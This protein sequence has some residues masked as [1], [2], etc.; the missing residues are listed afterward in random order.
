MWEAVVQEEVKRRTSSCRVSQVRPAGSDP[1]R[2]QPAPHPTLE[3]RTALRS[4]SGVLVALAV[5]TA[6]L[7]VLYLTSSFFMLEVYDRVVPS[8]SVPTLIA[9]ALLALALF[10][11][12]GFLDIIR[13]RVLIRVGSWLDRTLS[14][15]VYDLVA[16]LPL[17]ARTSGDGLQPLRDLD[18]LRTFLSGL[19]PTALFD[20]PWMPFYLALCYLFH[21]LIGLT[22]L[23]GSI[24]LVTLTILTDILTR[25]P[26]KQ[27]TREG[28]SRNALAEASR[29]NAEVLQAMGMRSR[30][31][32]LWV[33]AN[34]KYLE[35]QQRAFEISGTFGSLSKVLRIALQSTVL[36]VGGYLVIKQ[37]ASSG[38]IIA[39]AILTSRAL[40]PVELAIGH[41]KGLVTA[42]HGWQRL[43]QLTE[44][45]PEER[46]PTSLPAPRKSFTVEAVS[47]VPPGQ[48]LV[49][50]QDV[51]FALKAGQG[52]GIIGAS[53]SG[54]SSLVRA[55][56][57]AWIPARG[58]VRLDGA[59]LD[60]WATDS[61]GLHIGYLPQ[62]VEL[63]AG[64]VAQ[65]ISR[66][67]ADPSGEAIV[68]A[69]EAAGVH[70]LALRLPEGYD[71]PIGE[72][73]ASLSAGQRQRIA[74]ARALYGNP[75][76]VVLDEPNSNLD[77]EGDQALTHAIMRARARGG[78]IIV[79]AHRTTALAGVDQVLLMVD[80]RA[81]A[82]GP[83]DQILNQLRQQQPQQPRPVPL[84]LSP[85]ATKARS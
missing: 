18:Q 70:E 37:E 12:H 53:A 50:V 24:I 63:F 34:E 72:G 49:V 5:I 59:A 56:V 48:Q 73:G 47:V 13:T 16:R 84:R 85:E 65:N 57:G 10:A 39:G 3:L 33:E 60:Q 68:A 4:C 81:Q 21:P 46:L 78:I 22:A 77:A 26:I 25:S 80:G 36:G 69:A 45:L 67:E 9:L 38:I 42:R 54:K 2:A 58:K 43:K 75:F 35:N 32:A 40:A 76:L 31:A 6:T 52:L 14:G 27:A 23:V 28:A 20:I 61:L 29:R 62:D 17:R 83:K 1:P 7:N 82:F 11:L 64:T 71:T 55:I 66:F 51:S 79:V 44:H 74:L 30:V 8:R 41:W 19:G 15:R